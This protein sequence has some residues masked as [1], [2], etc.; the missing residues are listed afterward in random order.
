[1]LPQQHK[2]TKIRLKHL[3]Y[4]EVAYKMTNKNSS[5]LTDKPVRTPQLEGQDLLK[6]AKSHAVRRQRNEEKKTKVLKKEQKSRKRRMR[7]RKGP[8]R[9]N[10]TRPPADIRKKSCEELEHRTEPFRHP[11][12]E[13]TTKRTPIA[14]NCLEKAVKRNRKRMKERQNKNSSKSPQRDMPQAQAWKKRGAA[15]PAECPRNRTTCEP[16]EIPSQ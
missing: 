7:T 1:M 14:A 15:A 3:E 4:E 9:E 13:D 6:N 10:T 2:K 8:K 12:V 5:N 11:P 16:L